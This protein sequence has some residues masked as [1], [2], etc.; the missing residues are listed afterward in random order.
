MQ[1]TRTP[2][3]GTSE[4]RPRLLFVMHSLA[5]GGAET[6]VVNLIRLL[7]Q[8]A[9]TPEVAVLE[10][11]GVMEQALAI[12]EV[13]VHQPHKRPG[14]GLGVVRR[15]R[16]LLREREA[17]VLHTHNFASPVC[18]SLAPYWGQQR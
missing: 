3:T 6:M 12:R 4:L 7:E 5:V 10:R 2:N 8:T 11:G 16:R 9:L 17:N 1:A 13:M 18:A 15:L 14:I